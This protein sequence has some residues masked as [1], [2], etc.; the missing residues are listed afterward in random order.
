MHL[1]NNFLFSSSERLGRPLHSFPRKML[2]H[3]H[4]ASSTKNF[5]FRNRIVS[6]EKTSPT[7][8][9][10]SIPFFTPDLKKGFLPLSLPRLENKNNLKPPLYFSK[11]PNNRSSTPSIDYLLTESSEVPIKEEEQV[12]DVLKDLPKKGLLKRDST[13]MVFLKLSDQYI[14]SFGDSFKNKEYIDLSQ[15]GDAHFPVISSTETALFNLDDFNELSKEFD[16]EI[17]GLYSLETQNWPGVE[18]VWYLKISSPQ[19]KALREKHH[20][21]PSFKGEDFSLVV[22]TKKSN[23]LKKQPMPIMRINPSYYAA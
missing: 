18:K 7:E 19:L 2:S 20:L 12:L 13:G 6:S 15:S 16:F 10:L 11:G 9:F 14:S 3:L 1:V 17:K 22:G 23:S 4:S 21:S 5:F 8:K